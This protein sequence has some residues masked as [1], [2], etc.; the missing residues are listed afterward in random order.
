MKRSLL[1]IIFMSEKRKNLLLFLRNGPRRMEEILEVLDVTRHALLPQI[2]I[3]SESS[4]V[5]KEKD[6]CRLSE[7][8]ELVVGDM[9]P[10]IGTLTVL[11]ENYDYWTEHDLS[12]IPLPLLKR[13]RELGSCEII[14]P[15]LSDMFNLNKDI[16]AQAFGSGFVFGATAFL[17]PSYPS[18]L[19]DLVKNGIDVSIIMTENALEKHKID[20]MQ[21]LKMFLNSGSGKLYLYPNDM[22]LASLFIAETFVMMCLFDRKGRYDRKDLIF[23]NDA[24]INWGKELFGFYLLSS[25]QIMEI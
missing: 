4:L 1:E 14:E 15:E 3:L 12:S 17:H 23:R 20:H 6:V 2:K 7:I 19:V 25:H 8:G 9:L 13:I 22:K 24:A 5:I 21:E 10:L 11:E 18:L 16:I